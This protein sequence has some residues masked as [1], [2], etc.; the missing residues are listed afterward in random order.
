MKLLKQGYNVAMVFNKVPSKYNG[1]KVII[2]DNDD[3]RFL[4]E[5]GVIVG[6]KY[7]FVT[8]KGG[9]IANEGAFTINFAINV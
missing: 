6:L 4:D 1:Y 8:G 7:K 9:K 5:R 2:G 3:L